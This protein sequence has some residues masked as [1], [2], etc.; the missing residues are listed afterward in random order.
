MAIIMAEMFEGEGGETML[1]SG[2]D[3]ATNLPF[4]HYLF[5]SNI[6]RGLERKVSNNKVP[7]V[8]PD[9]V[10]VSGLEEDVDTAGVYGSTKVV[11]P[12]LP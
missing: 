9:A 8:P 6:G 2:I 4:N 5:F 1:W 7:I 10:A 12:L 11:L 3:Q